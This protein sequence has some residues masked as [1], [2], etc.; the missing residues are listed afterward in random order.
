MEQGYEGLWFGKV[1]LKPVE[2]ARAA[3]IDA[4]HE[5][6]GRGVGVQG[7]KTR[8]ESRQLASAGLEKEQGFGGRL[9]LALPAIDRLD[10]R[11]DCRAGDEALF[12]E[13]AGDATGFVG[14]CSGGENETRGGTGFG[15][16]AL[17]PAVYGCSME[18]AERNAEG[19]LP[20]QP[21]CCSMDVAVLRTGAPDRWENDDE[22]GN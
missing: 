13:G 1:G 19:N 18:G 4:E 15:H 8:F 10:R 21:R 3:G 14:V 2:V 5:K 11:E 16:G 7:M 6:L 22:Q 17:P 9:D 20:G 12:N